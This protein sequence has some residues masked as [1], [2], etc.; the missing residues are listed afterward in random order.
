[1]DPNLIVR[2]NDGRRIQDSSLI[3]IDGSELDQ[4][5]RSELW[6]CSFSRELGNDD[7]QESRL[8]LAND[9]SNSVSESVR[10]T[11]V[12]HSPS[13]CHKGGGDSMQG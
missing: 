4:F 13:V 7:V 9:R 6:K 11:V 2:L 1:M 10:A 3:E 5:E 12:F 8:S